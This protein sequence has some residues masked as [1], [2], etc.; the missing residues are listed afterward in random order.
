MHQ[1]SFTGRIA[2][3]LKAL[4]FYGYVSFT[5]EDVKNIIPQNQASSANQ[6]VYPNL[7]YICIYLHGPV[8]PEE[9][10][11]TATEFTAELDKKKKRSSEQ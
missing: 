4:K 2:F 9:C 1:L 3:F 8:F 11:D 6:E 5:D 10:Y 7:A